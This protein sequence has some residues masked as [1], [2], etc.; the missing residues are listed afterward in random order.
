MTAV[1][2]DL[3]VIRRWDGTIALLDEDEFAEHLLALRYP[4]EVV[5]A[6]EQSAQLCQELLHCGRR[7]VRRGVPRLPRAGQCRPGAMAAERRRQRA[8]APAATAPSDA[9]HERP[10]CMST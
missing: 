2:L 3:D 8:A 1:D 4:P 5:A 7:T 9:A 6:A 10:R